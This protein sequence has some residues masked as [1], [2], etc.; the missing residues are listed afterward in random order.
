MKQGRTD[1]DKNS[2]SMQK[3]LDDMSAHEPWW[4]YPMI[5]VSGVVD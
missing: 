4:V 3:Q 1:F 2:G 5:G